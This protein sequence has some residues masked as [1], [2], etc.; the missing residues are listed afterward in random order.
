VPKKYK[1]KKPRLSASASTVPAIYP[2]F[3]SVKDMNIATQMPTRVDRGRV[4]FL[5]AMANLLRKEVQ[6]RAPKIDI[7]GKET[8]YSKQLRI[9]LLGGVKDSDAV[10]IYFE[11][12]VAELTEKRMGDTALFIR[13]K[14]GSPEWVNVLVRF[15]PWPANM[16]P[17]KVEEKD[18]K[19]IARKARPDE[20]K[21]LSTRLYTR[22]QEIEGLLARAGA[23]GAKVVQSDLAVGVVIR[24]DVGYNVLRKEFGF[25]GD[26][27][28][29][30]WR[31]ALKVLKDAIPFL[32]RRFN[33]YLMTGQ[34]GVF[35]L[36][37]EIFDLSAG[38][39]QEAE[40]FQKE[41][42]PFAPTGG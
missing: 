35:E 12:A 25:D 17:L 16:L 7:G 23:T 2:S 6:K 4:L 32:I 13:A 9:A 37:G 33:K 11:H 14:S 27:Q 31:P 39:L 42:A 34:E 3:D 5:L 24:E 20:L 38:R 29:A 40:P 19:I 26:K 18:A 15:G 36:P 30:H 21:A 8:D 22:R 28:E 10:A 41:L 1:F